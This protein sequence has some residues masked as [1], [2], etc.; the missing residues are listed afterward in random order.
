MLDGM[1][2]IDV[3]LYFYTLSTMICSI[4]MFRTNL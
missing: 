1:E 3:V 4:V 2:I